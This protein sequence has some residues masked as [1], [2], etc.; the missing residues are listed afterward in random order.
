MSEPIFRIKLYEDVANHITENVR[1]GE[2]AAGRRLP[3]EAQLAQR[4]DVSRSTVREAVKSLQIAGILRSRT[5]SGTYVSDNAPM[6]IETRE[7]AAILSNPD[8][9]HDLVEA[10]YVLEP[11]LAAMAAQASTP[12]ETKR[13]F[14]I[15]D[16]MREKNDRFS[17]MTLGHRFHRALAEASHNRVLISVYL[18]L[19]SQLRGMRVLDSLTLEVYQQGIED[20]KNI[21]DAVFRGDAR[22]AKQQMRQHLHKDYHEYLPAEVPL[23]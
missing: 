14:D 21:A 6:V 20:H 23:D 19:E 5:G 12:E 16:G 9:L 1:T 22:V 8:Y 7:L 11:Q 2:W 13:L 18:S 17:L 10:R 3:T 4:F 15:V